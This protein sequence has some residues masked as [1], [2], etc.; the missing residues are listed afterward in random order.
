MSSLR[1]DSGL[2][3][4]AKSVSGQTNIL[5]MVISFVD[6]HGNRKDLTKQETTSCSH[7]FAGIKASTTMN[8]TKRFIQAQLFA[9]PLMGEDIGCLTSSFEGKD[10]ISGNFEKVYFCRTYPQCT[11]WDESYPLLEFPPCSKFQDKDVD[12]IKNCQIP[13]KN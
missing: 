5:P 12:P 1:M 10:F 4:T 2:R 11:R 7:H 8:S 13:Q 3:P 9:A 6:T